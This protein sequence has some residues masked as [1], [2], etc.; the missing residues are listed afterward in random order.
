MG[1]RTFKLHLIPSGIIHPHTLGV[2]RATGVVINPATLLQRDRDA[3]RGRGASRPRTPADALLCRSPD[4]PRRTARWTWRRSAQRGS[5]QI[6]TTGRGIGPAYTDK[7]ARRGLRL[8]DMLDPERFPRQACSTTSRRST[9]AC[10]RLLSLPSRWMARRWRTN[11]WSMPCTLRPYIADTGGWLT[12][13]LRAG[14]TV[15][16]EG[17]QGTLLDLDSGTYPF[18]TSSTTTAAGALVGLGIGH[19]AGRAR[20]GGD[21]GLPDAGRRRALPHRGLRRGRSAPAR[22]RQQ[23]VG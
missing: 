9:A 23:P 18:V 8:Q 11:T 12:R 21:Q 15:L 13:A 16:A 5:G 3:A 17:A 19:R 4:H 22:H 1:P 20:G 14:Q 7:A 6:G 10:T 2:H